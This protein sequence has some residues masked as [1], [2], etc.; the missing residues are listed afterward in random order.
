M[1]MNQETVLV[2]NAF[3]IGVPKGFQATNNADKQFF[4]IEAGRPY[5]FVMNKGQRESTI[6]DIMYLSEEFIGIYQKIEHVIFN[7]CSD[8]FSAVSGLPTNNIINTKTLSVRYGAPVIVDEFASFNFCV[9]VPGIL[10][11]GVYRLNSGGHTVE[12]MEATAKTLLGAISPCDNT[13]DQEDQDDWLVKGIQ[14]VK[15]SPVR[16]TYDNTWT[17]EIPPGYSYCMDPE[18]NAECA[19]TGKP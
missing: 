16:I 8:D 2:D 4:C 15:D 3:Y 13:Q 7:D 19:S 17:M 1:R 5:F 12:E 6:P 10:Y 14:T 18:I 9:I 11:S